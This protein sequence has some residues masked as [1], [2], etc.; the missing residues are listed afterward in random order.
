MV[1]C[2]GGKIPNGKYVDQR[3]NYFVFSGNKV[4]KHLSSDKLMYEGTYVIDKDG[5]FV[6]TDKEGK[7]AQKSLFDISGKTL[8][9]GMSDVYEKQ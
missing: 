5:L 6:A 1:A 3:G 4:S 8:Q 7:Q 9:L 2:G